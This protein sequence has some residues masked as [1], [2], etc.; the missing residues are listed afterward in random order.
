MSEPTA[1]ELLRKREEIRRQRGTRPESE[2]GATS[3]KVPDEY[4]APV[5]RSATCGCGRTFSFLTIAG[6]SVGRS[7]CDDCIRAEEQA[8]AREL[9]ETQATARA[10][11]AAA[12]QT[13]L[14][15]LLERAGA[16]PAEHGR[17]TLDNYDSR[18]G[19]RPVQMAR[20][21]L[22]DA[23]SAGQYDPVRGLYLYGGTGTGKT[24]LAVAVLREVLSDPAWRPDDVVF[25]HAAELLARIQSTYGGNGDTF[26]ILE[27]RFAAR[28]WILDD[29]GT[30]R[31]SDDVAR[32]LTLIFTRRAMRPTLVTSNLSPQQMES[33]RQE[34]ARVVSRLGPAYF[35]HAE[36][37]GADR[38]FARGA[39]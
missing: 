3:S 19:E 29:F 13:N 16:N 30:E 20:Q 24:H 6:A 31:S 1:E 8:V 33:S 11:A 39:A 28:L 14:L 18:A 12:R 15:A 36:V 17:S 26:A 10:A 4:F 38:R 25:D 37:K 7:Q 35:R 32:H 9:A 27:R 2:T 22:E 23:R 34:L 5:T 21:F